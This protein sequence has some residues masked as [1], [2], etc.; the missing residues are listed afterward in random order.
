MNITIVTTGQTDDEAYEL[1]KSLGMPIK[2]KKII[3]EEEVVS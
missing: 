3:K 2:Q 1:L